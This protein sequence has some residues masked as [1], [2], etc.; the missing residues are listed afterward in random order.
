MVLPFY[1][2]FFQGR[3]E[4]QKAKVSLSFSVAIR[5]FLEYRRRPFGIRTP[6]L[7]VSNVYKGE[8]YCYEQSG[9]VCIF[10]KCLSVLVN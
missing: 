3:D 6:G 4:K 10:F 5:S 2:F 8:D 9:R 1:S 7:Q